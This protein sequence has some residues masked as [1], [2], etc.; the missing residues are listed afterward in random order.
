MP[1]ASWSWQRVTG[2]GWIVALCLLLNACG[3][4]QPNLPALGT[5]DVVLAFGDSITYG[6][7]AGSSGETYP[8]VLAE[9]IARPVVRDGVPGEVTAEGLARLPASLDEYRPKLLL[10][11]LGGNDM[12]RQI[13]QQETAA[14]LRAMVRLARDR[15]IAVVLIGVPMPRLFSGAPA[16]Y[17]DIAGEFGL[18][19]E[20]RIMNEVL[21]DPSLKS[22]L[23]H[24]NGSGYRKVAEA[25]AELLRQSGAIR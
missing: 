2:A 23:V 17:E 7:G 18:P 20:G 15:G 11:C 6:V 3:R 14:N 24:A 8:E 16:F 22:D 13:P 9:L 10:L 25:V 12:L 1:A 4:A 21:K 5:D 19:Y